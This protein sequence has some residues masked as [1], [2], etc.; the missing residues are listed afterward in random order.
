MPAVPIEASTSSA[1]RAA[2]EPSAPPAVLRQMFQYMRHGI[3]LY[4]SE[5]RLI[6]ANPLAEKLTGL[7]PGSMRPGRLFSAILEDQAAAGLFGE[8]SAGRAAFEAR[9]RIDRS[10]PERAL[11]HGV[12]GRVLEAITDPTQD[13]GFVVTLTDVSARSRAEKALAAKA[14]T[15]EAMV[16]NLHQGIALFDPDRC[17]VVVNRLMEDLASLSAGTLRPGQSLDEFLAACL[18]GGEGDP[19][20]GSEFARQTAIAGPLQPIRYI[21]PGVGGR[22][23]DVASD[24]MPDGGFVISVTDIT[25]L[26]N[27]EAQARTQ[28]RLLRTTIETMQHGIVLFGPDRRLLKYNDR[29]KLDFG[30]PV[31]AQRVGQHFDDLLREQAALGVFGTGPDADRHL[32]MALVS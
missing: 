6:L 28:A 23:L 19:R 27:A 17:L 26:S 30:L 32:E 25:R 5:Q 20:P 31:T 11:L 12:Q 8:G 13:G 22:V 4:D 21:Q 14:A 24:P 2:A 1:D 10:R 15:L 7:A 16:G 3:A 29:A 18:A 9:R